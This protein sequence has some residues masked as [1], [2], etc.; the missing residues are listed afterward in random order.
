MNKIFLSTY[1]LGIS[2]AEKR[3]GQWQVTLQ[4]PKKKVRCLARHPHNASTIYAAI[5]NEGVW[6]SEDAGQNWQQLAATENDV[7]SIAVNPHDPSE[8]LAG[9]KPAGIMRSSDAGHSWQELKQFQAIRKWWW[10]S[11]ADPP[12][13]APYVNDLVFSPTEAGHALAGVELGAVVRS[14]DSG[15]NWSQHIKGTLRDCHSLKFHS[16]DGNF[17]YQAGGSG[18]G[19]TSSRDGG[20]TWTKAWKGLQKKYGVVCGFDAHDPEIWYVVTASGP[21]SAFGNN[22]RAYFYRRQAGQSWKAI[23]WQAHPLNETPTQILPGEKAG[24]LYAG[25][26]NGHVMHSQDYGDHWDQLPFKL[27]GIWFHLIAV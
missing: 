4:L 13:M 23:G 3:K 10:F 2:R 25:L 9:M 1:N 17:V 21:G 20:R 18:G 8:I 12:G 6:I 5:A 26:K 7:K 22:S 15:A 24:Q 16:T 19:A 11:P 27:D 14:E